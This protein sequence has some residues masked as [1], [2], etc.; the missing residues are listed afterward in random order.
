MAVAAGCAVGETWLSGC[1]NHELLAWELAHP[2]AQIRTS[3]ISLSTLLLWADNFPSILYPAVDCDAFTCAYWTAIP[4]FLVFTVV[5]TVM[6]MSVFVAVVFEVYKRQHAYI[7]L[8]EKL[9][10]RKALLAAFALDYQL[11]R[12]IVHSVTRPRQLEPLA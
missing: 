9:R 10:E 1:R 5:G 12:R 7:L 4:F 2:F 8:Q 6:V 11:P 3:L